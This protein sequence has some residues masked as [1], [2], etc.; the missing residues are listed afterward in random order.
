MAVMHRVF[1]Q[2]TKYIASVLV[3]SLVLSGN[4]WAGP[5][6]VNRATEQNFSHIYDGGWEFFV[7]G[8]VAIVDCNQDHYPDLFVAGGRNPAKLLINRTGAPGAALQFEHK[9]STTTDLSHVIGAY[10]L[11]I[12]S[13][14]LQDLFVLRVGANRILQGLGECRFAAANKRWHFDGLDRW[15]TAFS[16]T[17]EQDQQF[18]TLAVGNYVDRDDPNGPF[19][20]CDKHQLYRPQGCQYG[21]ALTLQPGYCALSM[22]I[23]DWGRKGQADLRISNDRHYYIRGGQEQLLRLTEKPYFYTATDG[24][25]PLSIWG[26][27]ISSRDITGDGL[28]EVFLTSMGDQKLRILDNNASLPTYRDASY[29]FGTTAHM[30]YLGDEGRPSSGWHAEFG[31]MD[32]DGFDDLFIAKG[33]VNQMPDS[34]MQDPN[35]LLLQ[36]ADG[37]F[38]EVGAEAGI[39]SVER[40]RGAGLVDLNL[41]GKL[42]IVLINRRAA[43]ELYENIS[44]AS[45]N[46]LQLEVRQPG[47]NR[48]AVGAWI[49]VKSPTKTWSREIT[50]GGGHASGRAGFE[51]FGLGNSDSVS[52]RIIWP[53]GISSAWQK[54]SVNQHLIVTRT[55]GGL[56]EHSLEPQTTGM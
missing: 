54:A 12:D 39:A 17:W 7:G 37:R 22:L 34:A 40:G 30:P 45:A 2:K 49:E 48:A 29:Q 3:A 56:V 9:T 52:Y 1:C 51:H 15:T 35:N 18:P 14:G 36:Q 42:D 38:I 4:S 23:S 32:N 11:D 43:I 44:S 24:W 6:F 13:D 16:A 41:D 53:D 21:P 19:G 27:G 8:G 46:W 10:P 25:N 33:N 5:V 47:I 55:Q 50:V 31:D 20:T 26:M 28:P